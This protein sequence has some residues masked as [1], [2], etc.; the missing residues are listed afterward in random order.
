MTSDDDRSTRV[1]VTNLIVLLCTGTCTE[2]TANLSTSNV[3]RRCYTDVK[4]TAT[5]KS[6]AIRSVINKNEKKIIENNIVTEEI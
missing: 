1:L 5:N 2:M 4:Y 3:E 6:T